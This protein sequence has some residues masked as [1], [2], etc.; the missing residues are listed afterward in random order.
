MHYVKQQQPKEC[1]G[2]VWGAEGQWWDEK[3]DNIVP[4]TEVEKTS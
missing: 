1:G 4:V 3:S 2:S